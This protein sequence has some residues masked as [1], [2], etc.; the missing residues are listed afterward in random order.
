MDGRKILTLSD[1]QIEFFNNEL[2]NMWSG[3]KEMK[4]EC[5][6]GICYVLDF[7]LRT[8]AGE[9]NI[10]LESITTSNGSI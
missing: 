5:M 7:L 10:S 1:A 9:I 3:D 2:C 8:Q 6:M 4:Y